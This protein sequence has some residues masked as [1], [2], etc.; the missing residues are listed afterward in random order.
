MKCIVIETSTGNRCRRNI[1]KRPYSQRYKVCRVHSQSVFLWLIAP[2]P[3]DCDRLA[4]GRWTN[5]RQLR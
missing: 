2:S 3:E 5:V 1:G 4:R